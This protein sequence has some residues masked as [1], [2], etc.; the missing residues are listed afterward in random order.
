V[1]RTCLDDSALLRRRSSPVAC[2]HLVLAAQDVAA[3]QSA[4]A[5]KRG[6]TLVV[7]E[8]LKGADSLAVGHDRC[9][10]GETHGGE[11]PSVTSEGLGLWKLKW[12]VGEEVVTLGKRL[13]R[14][15]YMAG[16]LSV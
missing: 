1:A 13:E 9:A 12:S 5:E 10:D 14:A 2:E 6:L 11:S 3:V 16:Y 8:S 4:Q 15:A 7:A